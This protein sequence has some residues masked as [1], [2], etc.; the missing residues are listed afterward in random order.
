MKKNSTWIYFI[1]CIVA[2][3]SMIIINSLIVITP[4]LHI[5]IIYTI[6]FTIMILLHFSF[7]QSHYN[8]FSNYT[9]R[10]KIILA[11]ISFIYIDAVGYIV[12]FRLTSQMNI[13]VLINSCTFVFPILM[14]MISVLIP[15]KVR[16]LSRIIYYCGIIEL[17][18]GGLVTII[19]LYYQDLFIKSK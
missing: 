7:F 11:I 3:F 8:T 4:E 15:E 9:L 19:S 18:A 6:A 13:I 17:F 12:Q 5:K 1:F 16:W 10:K 14:T 2:Y